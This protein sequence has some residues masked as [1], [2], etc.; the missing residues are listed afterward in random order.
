LNCKIAICYFSGTG[1][2]AYVVKLAQDAFVNAGVGVDLLK[3]EDLRH[4]KR[5]EFNPAGYDMLGIAHPVLG[6]DCPGLI[7]DFVR[8]LPPAENKP[9]FLLKTA[10]DYHA[11]N[12]SASHSIKKILSCKGY[13]P[14]YDEIVAMP[15]NWLMA[16]D[17]RLNRQLVEVAPKR[18]EAAVQRILA[19]ERRK[20]SNG[21]P[22]RII[23]KAIGYLEDRHG[24]KQFGRYLQAGASCTQCGK[25]ARDCPAGNIELENEKAVF[26]DACIWCMRCIYN[27]PQKAIDNKH[28][29][30]F[31]LKG[32]Y[33]LARI[34]ALPFEP[35]DFEGPKLPF[36]HKYFRRYFD[37]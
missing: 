36:W 14:F 26:G 6:F 12:H 23:L 31:I 18:V 20:L 9:V 8:A 29:N 33:S 27:C 22:L 1:N 25:C 28:M 30:L 17:D 32:G 13:D 2:T 4:K 21:L 11:V 3:I 5:A 35:I 16:Y 10:G 37:E 7:Y 34:R 24:A 19:G 15:V